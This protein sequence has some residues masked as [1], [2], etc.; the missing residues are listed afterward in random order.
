MDQVGL[1]KMG[2]ERG[3]GAEWIRHSPA[4]IPKSLIPAVACLLVCLFLPVVFSE[5]V[6]LLATFCLSLLG[7]CAVPFVY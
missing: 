3:E 4:E 2:R 5:P 1:L 7:Q 6:A